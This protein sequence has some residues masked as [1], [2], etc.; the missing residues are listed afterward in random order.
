MLIAQARRP[1]I[2]ASI[3]LPYLSGRTFTVS[4]TYFVPRP[5]SVFTAIGHVDT[6]PPNYPRP[7]SIVEPYRQPHP[8]SFYIVHGGIISASIIP[9]LPPPLIVRDFNPP[10]PHPGSSFID[11]G[12]GDLNPIAPGRIT[13][14]ARESLRPFLRG[15]SYITAQYTN[16]LI[17]PPPILI[18][19]QSFTP[20]YPGSV[21]S[22]DAPI[23]NGQHRLFPIIV[24]ESSR[25]YPLGSTFSIHG[26][27][28][29]GLSVVKP[30]IARMADVFF[31][32]VAGT[33]RVLGITGSPMPPVPPVPPVPPTPPAQICEFSADLTDPET[34][35][36]DFVC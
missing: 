12:S 2:A 27:P 21:F 16:T 8:G 23:D 33:G 4:Q 22:I 1:F 34:F 25:P 29:N 18:A 5:G 28:D 6:P 7:L 32:T 9:P 10:R 19:R 35:T 30:I 17:Q 11:I 36:Y 26:S 31:Q 13:T 3:Q 24:Q 14:S 20:S 15:S